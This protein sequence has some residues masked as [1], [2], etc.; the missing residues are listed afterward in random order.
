MNQMQMVYDQSYDKAN[1]NAIGGENLFGKRSALQ[2]CD[3]F[4]TTD[5][6]FILTE[7]EVGNVM[8]TLNFVDNARV[9][10]FGEVDGRPTEEAVFSARA[11][12]LGATVT[13]HEYAE[14]VFGG[15]GI[16]TTVSGLWIP[17]EPSTAYYIDVQVYSGP[18]DW[19]YTVRSDVV[20]GTD[21]FL[22]DGPADEGE[23]GYGWTEW[24]PGAESGFGAGDSAYRVEAVPE[25]GALALLGFAVIF[26]ARAQRGR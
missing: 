18:D 2:N 7:V 26:A 13:S 3:D 24:R 4:I 21:S 16:R 10:V 25:P 1:G 17:L 19:A 14:G 23:G 12:D 15:Y 9:S 5:T 11:S 22:R 20:T 8:F 6:G